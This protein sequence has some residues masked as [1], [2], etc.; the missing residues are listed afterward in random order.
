MVFAFLIGFTPSAVVA[1]TVENTD[2]P[3]AARLSDAFVAAAKKVEPA[4]V[5]IDAKAP[6]R[7]TASRR[8]APTGTPDDILEFFRRQMP[9]R[10][11]SAVGS[12]FIVDPTGYIVTN[13]HVVE[14]AVKLIVR[15]DSGEEHVAE[16]IGLD[17]ETDIAVLKVSAGR[18]L[19]F[20]SFGDSERARVGDWVLA[21]GSPF[22]LS[23]TVTAGII[24][25]TRRETPQGS[26]FQRFIQTDA[27]INR[28][29]S[30]G[31]L[32]DLDGRVIGVN[33]QIATSTGDYNGVGFALPSSEANV[34]YRQ[35]REN[36]TVRRGFLGVLLDT[37]KAEY[38]KVY[39]LNDGRGA[40]I[41]EVSVV[42]GPAATAGLK[43]GDVIV[44]FDGR[45]VTS[46]LDLI[47]KVA[48]TE[49]DRSVNVVYLRETGASLDRRTVSMR[50][51]TR[52]KS[53]SVLRSDEPTPLPVEKAD[54]AG[55]PFGLTV[56][57]VN[58]DQAALLRSEQ[59]RGVVIKEVNPRS[60]IADVK[61][62]SGDDALEPGD[63]VVR[64]NRQPVADSAAFA[65]LASTLKKGDAV[66]MHVYTPVRGGRALRLKIVQFTV[67]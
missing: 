52:P 42:D 50:L 35:I 49:P 22:G 66:V 64:I 13:A 9:P 15:L 16:L 8:G 53:T 60:F 58:A 56:E 54:E 21:I 12:G 63:I 29:N 33:S 36:G 6:P 26:P 3:S 25:Q 32:V 18:T 40:I 10:P 46:A 38:A 7:E 1:Q 23:R 19:P 67:Q 43:A 41:T 48:S 61:M 17:Q 39:G 45:E 37:V 30:G 4:V 47:A 5:S 20:V 59:A 28:G 2:T 24:S 65:R 55:K 27:A 62:S 14:G 51:G 31:P 34:V 57:E 11:T 44:E